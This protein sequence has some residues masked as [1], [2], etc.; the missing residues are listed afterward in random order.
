MPYLTRLIE[1]QIC[2][3]L[4]DTPVVCLLG[5]R[6]VGKTTLV[7]SINP[8]RTYITFDNETYLN[9]AKSDPVGFI[10]SLPRDVTIDEVQRA[11]EVLHAI[12]VIVDEQRKPGHF[13]LTGSANLLLLK[14]V[15]E[16]LAGRTET[17]YLDPLSEQEKQQNPTSF[18]SKLLS[19]QITAITNGKKPD[20]QILADSVVAGG[21]PE[22]LMR[23]SNNGAI[24]WYRNYI[25]ALI[26]RD[27]QDLESIRNSDKVLTLL[28]LLSLRTGSLLNAD[29]LAKDSQSTRSTIEK[30]ISVL[31][32]V[33]LIRQLPAW[34]SN[35]AK[36]L[37]KTPKIHLVDSG[38]LCYFNRLNTSDWHTKSNAFGPVLESYVLQQ[39]IAQSRTEFDELR[40]SHYRDKDQI[41]VDIV[42][43]RDNDVWGIEIKKA[44]SLQIDKDAK[45]LKKLAAL[46]GSNW[47]GGV[48]FY[49]GLDC[50]SISHIPN[51]YAVPLDW[52][53]GFSE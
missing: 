41:E 4:S 37:I 9:Q 43:E 23:T 17:L 45:G 1:N 40:F 51:T 44:V 21:Y 2:E 10:N 6:Q 13:I 47:K 25:N 38:L 14:S 53:K 35:E 29:S 3:V 20:Q 22:P 7:K 39:L 5:P 24:R 26:Q 50:L 18:L 49:A 34:H 19:N 12:K 27:I 32:K 46:T 8:S 28:R 30:Y 31:E 52:L 33:F 15:N 48:L 36:R 11:P 42:I 16:S